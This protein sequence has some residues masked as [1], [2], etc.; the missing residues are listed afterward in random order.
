[1]VGEASLA[2]PRRLGAALG[3]RVEASEV[4]GP[5]AGA[6]A[7]EARLLAGSEALGAGSAVLAL[8]AA[9]RGQ[10][11]AQLRSE[12]AQ[13]HAAAAAL[14]RQ[15]LLRAAGPVARLRAQALPADGQRRRRLQRDQ[16]NTIICASFGT[17]DNLENFSYGYSN[18]N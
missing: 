18:L 2:A 5:V 11:G 10:H 9:A 13:V 15:K 4:E 8:P 3:G 17:I 12:A 6:A 7:H 1:M 14:A 16:N